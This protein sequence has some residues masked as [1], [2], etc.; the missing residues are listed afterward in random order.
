MASS[1]SANS[2]PDLSSIVPET[3][4]ED[5][6]ATNFQSSQNVHKRKKQSKNVDAKLEAIKFK[7]ANGVRAAARKFGVC[8]KTVREWSKMEAA[9]IK[10]KESGK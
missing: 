1:N 6:D 3:D 8:R 5:D 7:K 4:S 2:L 10:A 9:L